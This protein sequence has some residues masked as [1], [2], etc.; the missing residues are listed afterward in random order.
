MDIDQTVDIAV[1]HNKG[2]IRIKALRLPK[3]ISKKKVP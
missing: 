3:S 2:K 1:P